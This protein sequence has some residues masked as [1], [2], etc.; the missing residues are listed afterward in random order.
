MLESSRHGTIG[1]RERQEGNATWQ[2][3]GGET[4][5][6]RAIL[7][8]LLKR[9]M[10]WKGRNTGVDVKIRLSNVEHQHA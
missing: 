3:N 7:F 8:F 10:I 2:G 9:E 5:S 1:Y 4:K 6:N